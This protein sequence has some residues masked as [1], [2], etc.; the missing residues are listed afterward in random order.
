MKARESK[1]QRNL[2]GINVSERNKESKKE[3]KKES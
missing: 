3:R 1:K 2:D